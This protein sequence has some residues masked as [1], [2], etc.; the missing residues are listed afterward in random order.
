M[1]KYSIDKIA[2]NKIEFFFDRGFKL[3]DSLPSKKEKI[4][5]IKEYFKNLKK[6]KV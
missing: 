1:K 3:L 5:E 6:R 2:I 4:N